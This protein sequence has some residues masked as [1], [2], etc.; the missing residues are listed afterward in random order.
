MKKTETKTN[1][2]SIVR[3]VLTTR[4]KAASSNA[5][6]YKGV[7]TKMGVDIKSLSAKDL[8]DGMHKGVYPNY[9]SVSAMSRK[10]RAPGK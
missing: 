10:L 7:L 6:L 8:L 1:N 2:V 9:D 3:S 5:S 4:K